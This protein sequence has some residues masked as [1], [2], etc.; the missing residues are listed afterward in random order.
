MS[1]TV[2]TDAFLQGRAFT[3][4][5]ARKPSEKKITSE[6]PYPY[7]EPGTPDAD[8]LHVN[9]LRAAWLRGA[10]EA[11]A[12]HVAPSKRVRCRCHPR[13]QGRRFYQAEA[14]LLKKGYTLGV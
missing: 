1:T 12:D 4:A 13:T 2:R 5:E 9:G 14:K 7:T 8:K 10:T 3:L 6:C 11:R